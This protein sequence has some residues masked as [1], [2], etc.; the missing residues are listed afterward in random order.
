MKY[1]FPEHLKMFQLV[2]NTTYIFSNLYCSL[3]S[4]QILYVEI[5]AW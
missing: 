2:F 1:N 3:S 4:V 5:D